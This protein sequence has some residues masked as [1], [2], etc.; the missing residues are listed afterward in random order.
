MRQLF[1]G[2]YEPSSHEIEEMWRT[3][4]FV[5]DTNMLLNMYRYSAEAR[6]SLFEVLDRLEDR[7]W[8]PYQ[9]A[10]EY[11]DRRMVVIAEQVKAYD[12][13]RQ[14]FDSVQNFV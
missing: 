4:V 14:M 11:H 3:C 9:V 1:P 10:L 2:Y 5:F 13:V 8:I 7:L 6:E 12:A